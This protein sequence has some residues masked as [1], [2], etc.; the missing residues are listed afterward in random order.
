MLVENIRKGNKQMSAHNKNWC[1]R[2]HYLACK[3]RTDTY[4]WGVSRQREKEDDKNR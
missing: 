2:E 3:M 1:S 4:S